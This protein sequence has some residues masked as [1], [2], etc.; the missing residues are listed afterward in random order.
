MRVFIAGATGVIGRQLVPLLV[1]EGHAVTGMTRS[2]AKAEWLRAVGAAA[3]LVDVYDGA[4]LTEAM[5][6]AAPEA[7][8][9]LLTAL[10]PRLDMKDDQVFA[11]TNRVRTEG[12]RR[13]LAA[14]RAAGARRFI[15]ESIAFLTAP[16]G[17]RVLDETAP[18]YPQA[19]APFGAAVAAALDLE[20]QVTTADGIEGIVLR[21]GALYGPGTAYAGDGSTAAEV[22]KRRFPIVGSGAGV[23]SFLH[24][25]D[26]ASITARALTQG[27]PGIYNAV[28]DEPAA[29]R[30]WL[31]VYAHAL[32]APT[33]LAVPRAVARLL[34]GEVAVYFTT[35]Q[36][37]ASNAKAKGALGWE[38]RYAS[39]REGFAAALG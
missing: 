35:A 1:R 17:P 14:A 13:L 32:G 18:P 15:A 24:V 3:K 4:A 8:L 26:A 11:A 12:T 20:R 39:W 34:A 31:P 2:P 5:A 29:L 36:R 10:P 37:G 28:D 33:P 23:F 7:V 38:P 21:Y 19:P 22:R 27:A 25:A 30:E 6:A 9:H 16:E